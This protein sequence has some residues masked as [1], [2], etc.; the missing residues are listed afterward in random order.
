MLESF[1]TQH[2]AAHISLER[3]SQAVPHQVPNER[4]R[5]I[6]LIDAIQCGDAAL[7][8][9]IAHIKSQSDDPNGMGNNFEEAAAYLLQFCLY[10]RNV[11]TQAVRRVSILVQLKM[12]IEINKTTV[13]IKGENPINARLVSNLDTTNHKNIESYHLS[14]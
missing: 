6:H 7:Q 9:A 1:I 3:C 10:Q 5:A 4:T 12:I 2:R 8:A 11:K 13:I 14:N